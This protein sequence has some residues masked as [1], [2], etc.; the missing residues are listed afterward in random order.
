M[1]K[2]NCK[3]PAFTLLESMVSML[4][5]MVVFSL[6]SLIIINVTT[7]GV[8]REKQNAYML[9]NTLRNETIQQERYI[10]ESIVEDDILVEKTIENYSK[11]EALKILKITASKDNRHLFESRDIVLI[12][13]KK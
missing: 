10:D 4:V 3:I 8:T 12:K 1:V 2:L 11:G 13:T 7:S 5:V 6:S 9:V